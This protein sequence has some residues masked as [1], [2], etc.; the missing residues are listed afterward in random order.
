LLYADPFRPGLNT[1]SRCPQLSTGVV[2]EWRSAVA[3]PER[4]L[5]GLSS[6]DESFTV[7]TEAVGGLRREVA[8][9]AIWTRKRSG[10]EQRRSPRRAVRYPARIGADDG[11]EPRSCTLIDI[12]QTGAKLLAEEAH[13]L[14]GE[15][16]LL[17]GGATR[18]CRIVWRSSEHVGVQFVPGAG[19]TARNPAE[20]AS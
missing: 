8:P 7:R 18:K 13:Q 16:V 9:M 15:F 6:L 17:L 19:N 12:S 20:P 2:D 10:P 4:M 3:E 5:A 1:L 14:P 11:S